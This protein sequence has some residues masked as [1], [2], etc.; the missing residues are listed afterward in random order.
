MTMR[1]KVDSVVGQ[2]KE[3]C[4]RFQAGDMV[5][6]VKFKI[7]KYDFNS[8]KVCVKDEYGHYWLDTN[9]VELVIEK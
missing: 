7:S 6:I 4:G 8:S 9:K 5:S 3:P 1:V 2:I